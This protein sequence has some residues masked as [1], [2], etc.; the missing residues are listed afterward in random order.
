MPIYPFHIPEELY[1]QAR[2]YADKHDITIAEAIRQFMRNELSNPTLNQRLASVESVVSASWDILKDH[3]KTFT[4]AKRID[5]DLFNIAK[6]LS[7]EVVALRRDITRLGK[8]G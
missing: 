4:A 7:A 6:K 1:A 3:Q 5:I 2:K 8:R